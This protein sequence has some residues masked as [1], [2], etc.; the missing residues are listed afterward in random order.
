VPGPD[1]DRLSGGGP[2]TSVPPLVLRCR[3]AWLLGIGAVAAT[4]LALATLCLAAG[5]PEGPLGAAVL[6]AAGA[7]T[8][9]FFLRYCLAALELSDRGFRLRGPLYAA[10][11]VGW[12]EVRAWRRRGAPSGPG[13]LR[14][15]P[16]GRPRVT[17]PLL[18]EDAHLL[19]LGLHQGRFPAW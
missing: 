6:F 9:S 13:F 10:V 5:S 2:G 15:E 3:T 19:E 12:S 4:F 8:T 11:D 1:P 7:L 14:V 18:Y 17:I 16:R